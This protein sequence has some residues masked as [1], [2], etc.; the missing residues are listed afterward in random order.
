MRSSFFGVLLGVLLVFISC[1]KEASIGDKDYPYVLT[2]DVSNIT[3]TSVMFNGNLESV[4]NSEIIEYGFVWGIDDIDIATSNKVTVSTEAQKGPFSI[5]VNFGLLNGMKQTVKT[6]VKTKNVVVYGNSVNFT[7]YGG[8][9]PEIHTF[10]P[11]KGYVDT[12]VIITGANFGTDKDDVTVYIGDVEV[13]IETLTN[14]QIDIR[15][16]LIVKDI[17]ENIRIVVGNKSAESS[18]KFTALAYWVKE[19]DF[20]GEDRYGASSFV[21]NDIGYIGLG[22]ND[23]TTGFSDL[24][25]Y[26]SINQQWSRLADFPSASRSLGLACVMNNKAYMGFGYSNGVYFDDFWSYDLHS[27]TWTKVSDDSYI[28]TYSDAYFVLNNELYMFTKNGYFIFSPIDNSFRRNY[29]FPGDYRF[30]TTGVSC[31]GRGYILAGEKTGN[32][33]LNDFWCYDPVLDT[34]TRK[35]DFPGGKR[36]GMACFVLNNKI[37]AGLGDGP[38]GSRNDFYEYSPATNTWVKLPDFSGE[39]REL[40]VSFSIGNKGYVGT[41]DNELRDFWVFEPN[42]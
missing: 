9:P 10:S 33:L 42:K 38:A 6:F 31:N 23:N 5:T 27:D 19:R 15:V 11:Q 36:K 8:I 13:P 37:Y 4:G 30:F 3:N 25:A 28:F 16:P 17:N 14:N 24:Y 21:L 12:R 35:A 7:S 1:K 34:W 41:G 18:A 29:G 32:K 22:T 20:P 26:N 39:E 2:Q 40:S